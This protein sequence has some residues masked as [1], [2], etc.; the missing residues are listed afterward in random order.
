MNIYALFKL[1]HVAVAFWF[2]A[3][4]IG[5]QLALSQAARISD[6]NV[7]AGLS[8]LAGRFDRLMVIPGSQVVFLIGLITGWAGGWPVL[9]FLEGGKANWVLASIVLFLSSLPSIPLIFLPSGKRFD[10][11]LKAARTQG[12]VTPALRAVITNRTVAMAHAYEMTVVALIV[13]LMVLKPF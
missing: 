6:V 10:E 8:D 12:E 1:L 9:G 3:G 7:F 2:I 5:R 4:L 11:A 13:V